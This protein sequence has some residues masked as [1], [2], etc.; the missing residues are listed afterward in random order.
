MSGRG[1]RRRAARQDQK[2]L[3]RWDTRQFEADLQRMDPKPTKRELRDKTCGD[4][5][6]QTCGPKDT[7]QL[8][9]NL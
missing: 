8:R 3:K 1:C 9:N 2:A 6:C 7:G 5:N 4:R